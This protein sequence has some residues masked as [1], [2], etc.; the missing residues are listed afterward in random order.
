MKK[1]IVIGGGAAGM[2]T[3]ALAAD[4]Y[5]VTLFEKNEK[6]GKKLFI[7][8]KGRC[9]LT[10]DSDEEEFLRNVVTNSKFLYSAIY[11]FNQSDVKAYF[12]KLGLKLKTERGN[13]VFPLSD[14]SSDVIKALEQELKRKKV[15]VH[16]NKKVDDIALN[17]IHKEGAD[18]E[19]D[20]PDRGSHLPTNCGQV[21]PQSL[22]GLYLYYNAPFFQNEPDKLTKHPDAVLKAPIG[23]S[24]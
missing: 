12:E 23:H 9:N 6:L 11:A 7:T 4:R 24:R 3:A 1:M 22:Q 17:I 18:P 5:K 10:N 20:N 16:L 8:G 21:Y 13:R 15:E 14:K 19:S 2:M